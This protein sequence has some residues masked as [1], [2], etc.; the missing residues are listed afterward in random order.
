MA[1][2]LADRRIANTRHQK[3]GLRTS[4]GGEDGSTGGELVDVHGNVRPSSP[5]D[6]D[7]GKD[8]QSA[9]D[10]ARD[11]EEERLLAQQLSNGLWWHP[12]HL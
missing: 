7:A 1:T 5:S 4:A 3:Y 2:R 11:A 6:G 10:V 12:H 9:A 8:E